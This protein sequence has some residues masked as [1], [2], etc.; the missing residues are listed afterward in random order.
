M[1]TGIFLNDLDQ[2]QGQIGN[3]WVLIFR[4]KFD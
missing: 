3:L 2:K 4:S 1:I